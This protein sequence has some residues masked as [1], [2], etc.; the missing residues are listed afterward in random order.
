MHYGFITRPNPHIWGGDLGVI[1][2]LAQGLKK[3]GHHVTISSSALTIP[4][5]DF[6]VLTHLTNPKANEYELAIVNKPYGTIGFHE[7]FLAYYPLATG[8]RNYVA[9]CLGHGFSTDNGHEF[10]IDKLLE[11]PHLA[12]YYGDP[13]CKSPL[14]RY[15]ILKNAAVCFANSPRESKNIL[16]DCPLSKTAVLPIVPGNITGYTGTPDDSFLQ[17]SGL[18]SKDYVL[19]VGRLE[20]RKNQLG[21]ILAMRNIDIPLVFL[22][23]RG[24]K[25]DEEVLCV[26]AAMKWR[27]APTLFISENLRP[28]EQGS[29]KVLPLPS[30]G[31]ESKMPQGMLLSAY[32]H[33]GLHIHPAFQE[34]PGLIYLEAARL[35]TPT[36]ASSWCTITDYFYDA[37]LGHSQLD[38]RIVYTEPHDIA[39]I[40]ALIPK[41]F[42]KRFA[43]LS[44][45][46]TLTYNEVDAAHQFDAIVH[47]L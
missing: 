15:E 22:A 9:Y 12:Y 21:T 25:E 28:F 8:F 33:A 17:W 18:R 32:H 43:P 39:G 37:T 7:D 13:L 45:H 10:C 38:G 6:F 41:M 40:E 26:E 23:T 30:D 29:V 47:S 14:Y 5:C 19:Q 4:K 1:Y 42:G 27:K 44:D 11:M 2:P 20:F 3:I 16:Q 34:L 31:N 24:F 36:I 35:G 46:P